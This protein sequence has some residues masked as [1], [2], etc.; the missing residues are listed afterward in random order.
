[1]AQELM[2]NSDNQNQP[3]LKG[4]HG[5]A[6][7]IYFNLLRLNSGETYSFVLPGFETANVVLS[8]NADISVDGELFA[9]VG[10]RK[11]IWSGKADSVYAGVGADVVIRSNADGTEIAVAGGVFDTKLPAFRV[12]P[13]EVDPVDV[14]SNETHSHRKIYHILGQNAAGRAGN[15]LIS[16][17]YCDDGN[18]SGYP[19]H[20]HDTQSSGESAHDEVYYYRFRPENGFGGQYWF[21]DGGDCVVHMTRN[22]DTFAFS[23]GYHPTVTS[24]GHEEYIFTILVGLHQR[25]LVQNFKEEYRPLMGMFPGVQ[26]MV[27]KFK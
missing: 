20:K 7:R 2:R 25:S 24:P 8:G 16:E 9:D 19:P 5:A 12:T 15:L 26:D 10:R 3:I 1:M 22:G 17:L 23:D 6:P 21:T 14:G 11:D 4:G 18:W 13:D 27:D